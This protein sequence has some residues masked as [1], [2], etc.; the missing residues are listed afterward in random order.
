MDNHS[1]ESSA[2]K[3]TLHTDSSKPDSEKTQRDD[4]RL[5]TASSLLTKTRMN[6]RNF[7]HSLMDK[8]TK[9]KT[10]DENSIP[11]DKK[12][13]SQDENETLNEDLSLL[14]YIHDRRKALLKSKIDYLNKNI[15]FIPNASL[16][17]LNATPDDRNLFDQSGKANDS[18][19]ISRT[20]DKS[21]NRMKT[22]RRSISNI[23]IPTN[24]NL[25]KQVN[26][27]FYLSLDLKD[28]KRMHQ[29]KN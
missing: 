5:H 27:K 13:N 1:G 21:P 25:K 18:F 22:T 10:I 14:N 26:R 17:N 6:L 11:L 19:R 8:L 28:F 12:Q 24:S 16:S 29:L 20:T 7:R 15:E 4:I 23:E 3:K 9:T 2:N